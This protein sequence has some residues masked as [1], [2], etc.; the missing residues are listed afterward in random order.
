MKILFFILFTLGVT[1][2]QAQLLPGDDM[3]SDS[4]PH[5]FGT[6]GLLKFQ[7]VDGIQSSLLS[8]SA[9]GYSTV[10][11]SR[12][13]HAGITFMSGGLNTGNLMEGLACIMP[14]ARYTFFGSSDFGIFLS[15]N[16]GI[17]QTFSNPF[18]N[19]GSFQFATTGWGAS[20]W[21]GSY[22]K[23]FSWLPPVEISVGYW[24]M[25]LEKN[26]TLPSAQVSLVF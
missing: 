23:L 9:T 10:G 4:V 11:Q 19:V 12:S 14:G 7:N 6:I 13:L 17:L 18:T 3:R 25:N 22:V 24:Y 15:G 26:Y 21:G 2:V 20:A 5:T 16:A 8:F 1:S